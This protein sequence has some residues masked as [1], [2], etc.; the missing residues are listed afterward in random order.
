[1]TVESPTLP[2]TPG[3]ALTAIWNRLTATD[4]NALLPH[5]IGSTPAEWLASVLSDKGYAISASTI[6]TYRRSLRQ[7]GTAQ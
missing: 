5:L 3:K 6:R 2:G 7:N 4:R 1:V